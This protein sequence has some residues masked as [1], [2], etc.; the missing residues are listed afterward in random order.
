MKVACACAPVS[1][2]LSLQAIRLTP[3]SHCKREQRVSGA[4]A[5]RM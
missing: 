2:R 1:A 5:V 3:V 4:E